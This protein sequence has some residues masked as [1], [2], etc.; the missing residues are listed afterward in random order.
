MSHWT[1]Y[2]PKFDAGLW[3]SS[4]VDNSGDAIL[5]KTLNG[6]IT[7]WNAGAEKLFG[8]AAAE[9]IGQPITL[10]IPEDRLQEEADIIGKLRAGER[11]D[12]L[13]TV[14]R[15]RDGEPVHIEVT[16][17]PVRNAGGEIIGAS[18]IARD[19]G[20]RLRHAENQRLLVREMHHRIK[21]LLSI[22]QGLVRVGRRRADDVDDF[23]NDLSSRITALGAAQQLVLRLPGEEEPC[24]T[25]SEVFRAVLE[26]YRNE[27]QITIARCDAPVGANASTSLALLLHELATNAVKYGALSHS[28]GQLTVDIT[29]ANA[30]ITIAW[31]EDGG[32]DDNGDQ[33]FG[34]ELMSAALRGLGGT[35][36]KAWHGDERVVTI[37]LAR[38]QLAH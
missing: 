32:S 17:S 11:I 31:R 2:D 26:P 15:R 36:E 9:A 23:A 19:I 14:R 18:T 8:F 30:T 12:R 22:V 20:E 33:G 24:V 37:C 21:N 4:V 38:V 13:E 7:S 6:I 34:T 28:D 29:V 35:I 27:G 1:L 5:S 25:L 3:L 10:I 16:I